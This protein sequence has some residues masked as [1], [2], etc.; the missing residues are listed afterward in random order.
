MGLKQRAEIFFFTVTRLLFFLK[1]LTLPK[2]KYEGAIRYWNTRLRIQPTGKLYIG[3]G[4]SLV[5]SSII[6]GKN[7]F[8]KIDDKCL[9]NN[10]RITL[11][12][13]STAHFEEG[14]IL[15]FEGLS[16]GDINIQSGSIHFGKFVNIKASSISIRFNAALKIGTYSGIG[17]RSEIVCDEAVTIGQYCLIS[18]NVDIYDTNSHATHEAKRRER[19]EAGYPV[20]CSEVE[21]P[22]TAP[23]NISDDVWI[24]KNS[25]VLKGCT[26]G[27]RSIIGLG[28]KVTPGVYPEDSLIVNEKSKTISLKK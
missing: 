2:F 24:G 28:T 10:I 20:G 27:A 11:G 6:A 14:T 15:N 8:I 7:S 26:I 4:V 19:I 16:T 22:D 23:V 1:T 9:L 12:E 5:N 13:N 17:P 18:S 21:K 25:Q 3:R